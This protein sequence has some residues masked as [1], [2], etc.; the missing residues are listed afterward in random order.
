MSSVIA[1][2]PNSLEIPMAVEAAATPKPRKPRVWTPFAVWV[3]GVVLGNVFGLAVLFAI[4]IVAGI[5]AQGDSAAF[6]EHYTAILSMPVPML[7]AGL[8]PFQAAL[9]IVAL[10]GGWLSKEPLKERLGLLPQ[11]GRKFGVLKLSSMAAFT[12][13]GAFA[14]NI[15]SSFFIAPPTQTDPLAAALIDASFLTVTLLSVV[16]SV[17]PATVEEILFRGYIQRRLLKRWSPVTAIAVSS[18]LFAVSHM[19]SIQHII[20]VVPLAVVAGVLAY[21]TNSVKAGM[22]VHGVHNV[23]AVVLP[24]AMMAASQY[25]SEEVLGLTFLAS[26]PVL[27]LLGLPAVISL[28]RNPKQ[29]KVETYVP[30]ETVESLSVL[31]R[32]LA[33]PEYATES[34]N[35][36]QA[37]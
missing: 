34:R 31:K 27:G 37:V 35:T 14:L 7:M 36:T 22:V 12:L 4:A 8:L 20:A 18:L 29:P 23:A 9:L 19:D 16:L 13:A 25:I 3:A 10:L 30:E 2:E 17:V 33:L 28:L 32:E 11:T 21:K 26:I 24:A 6:Q 15:V 5:Q 1:I